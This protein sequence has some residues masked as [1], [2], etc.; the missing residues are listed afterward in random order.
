MEIG[1]IEL[2]S[3]EPEPRI[4]FLTSYNGLV[5]I[6]KTF[7]AL[8]FKPKSHYLLQKCSYTSHYNTWQPLAENG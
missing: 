6:A 3:Q 4:R 8:K 2:V 5:F 1:G 7:F